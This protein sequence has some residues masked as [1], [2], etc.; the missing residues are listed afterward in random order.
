[1]ADVVVFVHGTGVREEGWA[2]SFALVR[3]RL[4]GLDSATS[5]H[6]CFWG[7][8]EGAELRAGGASIP[9]YAQTRSDDPSS[10][11]EDLALWAVLYTDP[12]YELRLLSNWPDDGGE[13][14]PGQ[15]PTSVLFSEQIESF[16]PSAELS[17]VLD[18]NDL[19]S[20]FDD[21][22]AS[23]RAAAEFERV[24]DAATEENLN[25]LRK[26][27]ARA[28]VAFAMTSAEDSGTPPID[29]DTRDMVV[30]TIATDLHGY[31]MGIASWLARPFKGVAQRAV[32]WQ[33]S[34]KRGAVSDATA[35]AAGDIIRYQARGSGVRRYI[36]QVVA[37]ATAADPSRRVTLLAHSLG[38]I[39]CV[40]A[41]TEEP[42][43][44][45]E[46]LIT[47]GSQ[48]PFFYEIDAL[49]ALPYGKPLPDQFPAWLNIYDSRDFLSYIAAG[50]FSGRVT[51]KRVDNR[52]PFPQAHSAYWR[53]AAV[54]QHI[55]EFL[56]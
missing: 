29:G 47:V 32:T 28:L 4:R 53:N 10:A 2:K 48:A 36:R 52:Q 6:G 27:V 50:V 11:D 21:A 24:A 37:D 42:I 54:W 19:R 46:R 23:L 15:I 45:V 13:L 7:T 18:S 25:E 39:A 38:G 49:S 31:G 20:H 55:T 33:V 43:P 12:W 34:R 22:C 17:R 3:Q 35:P 8:S 14:A 1:M 26:A 16:V 44:G 9:D 41:L 5:V 30:S 40:D 56:A 51:D